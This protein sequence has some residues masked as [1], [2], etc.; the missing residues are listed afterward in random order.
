[1]MK[2]VGCPR[3]V[4]PA[5]PESFFYSVIPAK[6]GIQRFF[7]RNWIPAFAGM[8]FKAKHAP[9]KTGVTGFRVKPGMTTMKKDSRSACRLA[10]AS[11]F[12]GLRE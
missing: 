9:V 12:G 5:C 4:I 1:M 3:S 8:T 10:G 2:I 7:I 11:V 6:A